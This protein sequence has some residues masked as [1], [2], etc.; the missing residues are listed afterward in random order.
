MNY[1]S[2]QHLKLHN[3]RFNISLC[4][5]WVIK[6]K[7]SLKE[8]EKHKIRIGT[9]YSFQGDERDI[10]YLSLV[11]DDNT[12]HSSF[13][14]INKE[15]VFNVMITRA[16]IEQNVFY[17]CSI[18]KLKADSILRI[19]LEK[20]SSVE[21]PNHNVYLDDFVKQFCGFIESMDEKVHYYVG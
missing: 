16:R 17:S 19:Y 18:N 1:K 12:H 21:N 11:V 14:H 6:T 3:P 8:I 10:V 13:I 15:D 2:Y 9:P 4:V 7:L 5:R 20:L